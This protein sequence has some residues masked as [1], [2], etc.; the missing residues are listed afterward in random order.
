MSFD[1]IINNYILENKEQFKKYICQKNTSESDCCPFYITKGK[2]KSSVCQ[3][4]I[5]SNGYCKVHS[6]YLIQSKEVPINTKQ[7]Y[8]ELIPFNLQDKLYYK[9]KD[10]V[11][12]NEFER[13]HFPV[14]WFDEEKNIIILNEE[15]LL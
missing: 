2:Y 14:G 15:R 4:E 5:F 7:T 1:T 9:T 8:V 6:K 13:G 11:L 10:N 3:R 12:Y